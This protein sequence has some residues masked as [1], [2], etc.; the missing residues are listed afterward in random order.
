MRTTA[1]YGMIIQ[2]SCPRLPRNP[3]STGLAPK[4][5]TISSSLTS[6]CV[7]LNAGEI[8]ARWDL[9]R[10]SASLETA[11][12]ELTLVSPDVSIRLTCWQEEASAGCRPVIAMHVVQIGCGT[13]G[14]AYASA[15]ANK[16]VQVTILEKSHAVVERYMDTCDIFHVEDEGVELLR[17]VAA[18]FLAVPTPLQD[19]RLDFSCL[20]ATLLTVQTIVSANPQAVVVLR[21]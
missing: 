8:L 15:L 18:V 12:L 9:L 7:T 17:D 19:E 5:L 20:A 16:G 4:L 21:R 2:S 1:F 10:C 11:L 6:T 14:L 13:I 3:L